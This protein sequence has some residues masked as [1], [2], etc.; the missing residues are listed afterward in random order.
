MANADVENVS[1][2]LLR[3]DFHSMSAGI[4]DQQRDPEPQYQ[5]QGNYASA[6]KEGTQ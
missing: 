4:D 5:A 1:D 3:M 6:Q 2:L